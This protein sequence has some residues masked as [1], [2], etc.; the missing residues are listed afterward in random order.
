[1]SSTAFW[2]SAPPMD[3]EEPDPGAYDP[4]KHSRHCACFLCVDDGI[5]RELTGEHEH[6]TLDRKSG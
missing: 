3:E 5:T 4:T 2:S 1:M 6:Y